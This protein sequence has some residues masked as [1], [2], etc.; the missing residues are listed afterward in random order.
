MSP[1]CRDYKDR[2]HIAPSSQLAQ[3]EQVDQQVELV[4]VAEEP[5]D[6]A[7]ELEMLLEFQVVMVEMVALPDLLE[8]MLQLLRDLLRQDR[9]VW[10][11]EA[12]AVVDF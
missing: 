5:E 6:L 3:L 11:A 12:V 10:P 7:E 8:V 2:L 9:V 4:V 1:E